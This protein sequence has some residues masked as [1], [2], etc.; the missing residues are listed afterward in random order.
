MKKSVI[1]DALAVYNPNLPEE[2]TADLSNQNVFFT[3]S[4]IFRQI[5][6]GLMVGSKSIVS[7]IMLDF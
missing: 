5:L 7:R 2:P 3:K 1:I 4:I 6:Y